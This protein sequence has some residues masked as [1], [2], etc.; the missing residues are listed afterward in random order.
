MRATA[1]WF[2]VALL[3]AAVA[4]GVIACSGSPTT[5]S[6]VESPPRSLLRMTNVGV[7]DVQGLSAMFPDER[8]EFGDVPA[9]A[10]STY[11]TV[12]RGVY[13]YAAYEFHVDAELRSQPVIDWVG[14]RPMSGQAFTYA[15][16]MVDDRPW[17]LN[18]RLV[19]T[20]RDR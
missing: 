13:P 16:E 11:R 4:L 12:T 20:S 7:R 14:E 5:A 1:G 9:G 8:V 19:S 17:G 3:G 15:I 6:D 2:G 10:T 18:I